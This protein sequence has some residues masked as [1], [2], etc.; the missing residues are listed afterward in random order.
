MGI[1]RREN[2]ALKRLIGDSD[3]TIERLKTLP[4]DEALALF[5]RFRAT[6]GENSHNVSGRS[7]CWRPPPSP[8]YFFFLADNSPLMTN[9]Y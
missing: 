1:L 5:H 3:G 9:C 6:A 4:E 7:L 2:E 8:L